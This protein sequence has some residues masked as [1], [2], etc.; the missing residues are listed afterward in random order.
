ML[1]MDNRYF[2]K[3]CPPIMQDARFITN[4]TD[5]RILDQQIRTIN[6]INDA[7]LYKQFL[8]SNAETIMTNERKVNMQFNTCYT[9]CKTPLSK[10]Q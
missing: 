8:Q 2:N 1:Y 5:K 4:Y 9:D 6:K 7:Y 3:G 10:L